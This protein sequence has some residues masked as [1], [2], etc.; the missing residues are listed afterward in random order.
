MTMLFDNFIWKRKNLQLYKQKTKNLK[1][2]DLSGPLI[3][4]Q[5]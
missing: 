5:F 1:A 3:F 4:N 2:R